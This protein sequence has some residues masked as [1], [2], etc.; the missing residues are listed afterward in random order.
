VCVKILCRVFFICSLIFLGKKKA[1]AIAK[2]LYK[3][4]FYLFYIEVPFA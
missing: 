2:A 3:I 4:M 1:F